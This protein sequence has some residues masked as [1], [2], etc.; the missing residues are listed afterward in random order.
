MFHVTSSLVGGAAA[1]AAWAL[2]APS[3]FA[4]SAQTGLTQADHQSVNR[5]AKGD[6]LALPPDYRQAK[7]PVRTVE[8][9]GV[10]DAAI[11]Y[12]DRDG[13]VL[14]RTDPVSNVTVISRGFVVPQLT[15]RD[16]PQSQPTPMVAPHDRDASPA[17]MLVGC[18]PVASPIVE[19]GLAR[20]VGRC[21]S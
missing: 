1:V 11:V 6:R 4:P 17:A 8:V 12:R 18:E 5:T 19:P 14:F 2:V 10:H 21:L 7:R 15:L 16:T 3:S 20:I 9:I 13:Q